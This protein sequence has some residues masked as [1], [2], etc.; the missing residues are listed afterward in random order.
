LARLLAG[1]AHFAI[2]SPQIV[3]MTGDL[4]FGQPIFR[5]VLVVVE[6]GRPYA[7]AND[8]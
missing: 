3:K 2:L 5:V 1:Y 4:R 6:E 7:P 8:E